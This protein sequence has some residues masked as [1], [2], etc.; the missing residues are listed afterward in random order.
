MMC[1]DIVSLGNV[2]LS[3]SSTRYPLRAS[4]I[5]V[6]DPAQRAPTTIASY[7]LPIAA[8]VRFADDASV[9][10]GVARSI[11]DLP[12]LVPDLAA[13]DRVACA[14]ASERFRRPSLARIWLTWCSAVLRLMNSRSAISGLERP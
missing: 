6:G 11:G 12:Y 2:A 8:S 7:S 13:V 10:P 5:A 9:A 1:V 3:T 4:S 14:A